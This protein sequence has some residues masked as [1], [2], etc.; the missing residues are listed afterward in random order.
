[1]R[2][3]RASSLSDTGNFCLMFLHACILIWGVSGQVWCEEGYPRLMQRPLEIALTGKMS[4]RCVCMKEED[5]EQEGL[6]IYQGC[7]YHSQACKV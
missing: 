6:E 4:K 1:M 5:L 2:E 3:Q 7:D